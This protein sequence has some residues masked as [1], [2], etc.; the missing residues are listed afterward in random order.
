MGIEF[1]EPR[2]DEPG[3][4]KETEFQGVSEGQLVGLTFLKLRP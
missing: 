1:I 3:T 4:W 2:E